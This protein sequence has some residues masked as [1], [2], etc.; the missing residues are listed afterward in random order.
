MTS[1]HLS[2]FYER[3]TRAPYASNR[4]VLSGFKVAFGVRVFRVKKL[5]DL[6]VFGVKFIKECEN[7]RP[8]LGKDLLRPVGRLRSLA[9][10]LREYHGTSTFVESQST[11]D[12]TR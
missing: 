11:R 8:T 2:S 6:F 5:M 9:Q 10:T 3:L 1:C 7:A 4:V 12:H